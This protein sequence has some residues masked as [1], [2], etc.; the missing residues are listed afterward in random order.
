MHTIQ[1]RIH[2]IGVQVG[3]NVKTPA[4]LE[5]RKL[6]FKLCRYLNTA[7]CLTYGSV[8]ARLPKELSGYEDLGLLT[9]TEIRDLAPMKNKVRDT[10]APWIQVVIQELKHTGAMDWW[11]VDEQAVPQRVL[12]KTP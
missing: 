11:C 8:N 9:A 10:L 7:H 5:T 2:D 4:S 1:A 6:C 3:G 12:C